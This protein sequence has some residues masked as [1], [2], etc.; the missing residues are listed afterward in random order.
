MTLSLRSQFHSAVLL[1]FLLSPSS[2]F[3][4][5]TSKSLSS[6]E[7]TTA[8]TAS[9]SNGPLGMVNGDGENDENRRRKRILFAGFDL[10]TSGCRISIIESVPSSSNGFREVYSDSVTWSDCARNVD[11][12]EDFVGHYDDPKSWWIAIESLL[13]GCSS[14]SPSILDSVASICV[15]GTSASC[16][17]ADRTTLEVTRNPRMYDYDIVTSSLNAE[18]KKSGFCALELIRKHLPSKH[19]AQSSTGSFAKLVKWILESPLKRNEFLCHQSDYISTKLIRSTTDNRDYENNKDDESTVQFQPHSDWQNCLKLGYDVRNLCWPF[20]DWMRPCLREAM[21]ASAS[22]DNK[23]RE[24]NNDDQIQRILP[25]RVVSPGAPLSTI[26][27]EVAK[28]LGLSDD[29]IVV[30]G[31]TDSNAAFYAAAASVSRSIGGNKS[32]GVKIRIPYGSAVT[33]LGSTTAI[34]F[35]SKTYVED[36]TLGVYSHRF[37]TREVFATTSSKAVNE[38]E[39]LGKE[40]SSEEAWLVGGASNAG[41]AVFRALNFTDDE[42][43]RRSENIDP[44]TDSEAYLR[45]KYYP[46]LPNKIGERFP[47][48]DATKKP[49]LDPLPDAEDDKTGDTR[50]AYLKGLFQSISTEV[51]RKGYEVLRDLGASP[52]FPTSI[53]TAGGGSKNDVWTSLRERIM[54][55]GADDNAEK[56]VIGKAEYS[57][58]SYGAA[59]LAAAGYSIREFK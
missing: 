9:T 21:D 51:E 12:Y 10:G 5:Q 39:S 16:L 36:S 55:E 25:T 30:G 48:A 14:L 52:P 49:K 15:S 42:L 18:D 19:T 7:S 17:I 38:G 28:K 2:S 47:L 56:V 13:N 8:T 34:K 6:S 20:E 54:N 46:L 31:T 23:Y 59:L 43:K 22:K 32:T 58:A 41:C 50:T 57:E 1:L 44:A 27:D 40:G 24:E 53:M 33:S 37:P 4:S 29:V 45:Y 35:L 11:K 26:D 3:L